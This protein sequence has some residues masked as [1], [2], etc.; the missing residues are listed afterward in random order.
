MSKNLCSGKQCFC[1]SNELK[2]VA[3]FGGCGATEYQNFVNCGTIS[4][5]RKQYLRQI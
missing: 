4:R 1:R 5:R 2:C 3:A